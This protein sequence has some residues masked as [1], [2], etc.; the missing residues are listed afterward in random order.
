M[1]MVVLILIL[2]ILLLLIGETGANWD[3]GLSGQTS[4]REFD[5]MTISVASF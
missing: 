2:L 4:N 5:D 1:L 3:T